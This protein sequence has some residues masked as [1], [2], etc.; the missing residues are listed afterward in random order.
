[1]QTILIFIEN[2]LKI[3]EMYIKFYGNKNKLSK[4]FEMDN[5]D[6]TTFLLHGNIKRLSV[7]YAMGNYLHMT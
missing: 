4:I 6:K 1:M 2:V 3:Y 5:I 7:K